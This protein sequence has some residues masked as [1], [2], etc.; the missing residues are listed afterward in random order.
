ML[1]TKALA[2]AE[3]IRAWRVADPTCKIVVFASKMELL[4]KFCAALIFNALQPCVGDVVE[5]CGSMVL[6]CIYGGVF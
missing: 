6:I 5:K 2:G 3:R 4:D 1:G